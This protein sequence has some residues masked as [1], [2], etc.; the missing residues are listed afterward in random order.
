MNPNNIRLEDCPFDTEHFGYPCAIVRIYEATEVS[1]FIIDSICYKAKICNIKFLTIVAE[2]SIPH[3]FKQACGTLLEFEGLF[4]HVVSLTSNFPQRFCIMPITNESWVDVLNL[5]QYRSGNRYSAD[6][7]L[8]E[9]VVFNHKVK[10]YKCQL[11]RFPHLAFI[12][13]S[14]NGE[15]LG[16]HIGM[17]LMDQGYNGKASNLIQYDLVVKPDYRIGAVAM[18]LVSACI[19]ESSRAIIPPQK[20]VT[21]IYGDNHTSSNFFKKIGLNENGKQ[22]N[23]YHLW[24]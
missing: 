11:E 20:V 18:D 9:Q 17:N 3:L 15:P 2:R 8:D 12:A 21:K 1:K 22:H 6:P 5:S 16:F 7:Y 23:Y 19:K 14:S 13:Y 4:E 24:L 10:L